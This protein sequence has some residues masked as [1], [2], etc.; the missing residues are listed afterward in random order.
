MIRRREFKKHL[1]EKYADKQQFPNDA[2]RSRFIAK[3]A[4]DFTFT[5]FKICQFCFLE[6]TKDFYVVP[7]FILASIIAPWRV[8][9]FI[10]LIYRYGEAHKI[11]EEITL[12]RQDI[13]RRLELG[14]TDWRTL[15]EIVILVVVPYRL[16][17]LI[18]ILKKNVFDSTNEKRLEFQHCVH[19]TFKEFCKDIIYVPFGIFSL[20]LAPWRII[21]IYGIL[22]SQAQ[23]APTSNDYNEIPS[24]RYELYELFVQVLTLDYPCAFMTLV[25]I[26]TMYKIP[27]VFRIYRAFL[28]LVFSNSEQV[29]IS[30]EK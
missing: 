27:K 9:S 21:T 12:A 28:R 30:L 17:F 20:V 4:E 3:K 23:R 24:K 2:A 11:K 18:A 22:K 8:V 14:L 29:K 16:P 26:L 5:L 25:L 7:F 6:G 13:S 15:I 10:K 1:A 19:A